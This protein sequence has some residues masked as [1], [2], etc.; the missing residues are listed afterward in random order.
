[1]LAY[2]AR[3][4]TRVLVFA[5]GAGAGEDHPWMRR[6]GEGL[7]RRGVSVVTFDFPYRLAGRR[8]P[9]RSAVLERSYRDAVAV[10]AADHPETRLFVGGKSMGGRIATQVAA[11]GDLAPAPAGI[12]CIGYPLH[13]PGR[14]TQ[15]RD[16]HLP[17]VTP[18]V[19][20]VQG[21]RD[22]F[23]SPD[24]MTELVGWLP[25]ATLSLVDGG[26]HSLAVP[27]RQDPRGAAFEGA[28]D[29]VA[30]WIGRR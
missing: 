22:P 21:T 30:E 6:V 18:P 20:F 27:V 15:R 5:P 4:E 23:A 28:L 10:V 9:D 24:E 25:G 26:D 1:M 13:P 7:A 3:P 11:A 2:L 14:P 19:L 12:V 17:G 8:L 29:T 16:R